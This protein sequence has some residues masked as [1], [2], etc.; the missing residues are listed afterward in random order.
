MRRIERVDLS[1]LDPTTVPTPP[2]GERLIH[3]SEAIGLALRLRA[4]GART[5]IALTVDSGKT[6]RRT[7]GDATTI[8]PALARTLAG[9]AKIG[10]SVLPAAA[11]FSASASLAV[12]M[13]AYLAAGVGRHWTASTD[14]LMRG[15]ARRHIVPALGERAVRDLT[16]GDVLQWHGELRRRT[17]SARM[18]LSTLSGMMRYAEDHGLRDPGSNPCRGL[19]KK[20]SSERGSHLPPNLIRRIWEALARNH[21]RMPDACDIIRLLLL[22]G[23]RKGEIIGLEWDRIADARAVLETS[24]TGPRTIWLNT[25]ARAVLD[26]RRATR[27]DGLVFPATFR[28]G[29]LSSIDRQWNMIRKE[30]GAPTLRLHD[31]RHHYAAVG[32]SNGLDLKL[33]GALLGHHDIDSTLIYAHLATAS[34]V[35]SADRVSRLIGRASG[36]D[37]PRTRPRKR[38]PKGQ[39]TPSVPATVRASEVGHG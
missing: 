31:L 13:K 38:R 35:K 18:A 17:T 28:R 12:V 22:T 9:A 4:S 16:R 14:R 7:L 37:Q 21:D 32:V 30:A 33:V 15:V 34:L 24:K 3:D 23:A 1:A 20:G 36:Q 10:A 29:A 27:W 11:P 6:A 8:P 26:G 19:R 5:W 2:L 25:P 39:I